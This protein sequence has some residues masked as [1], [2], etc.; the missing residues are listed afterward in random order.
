MDRVE[1]AGELALKAGHYSP[2]YKQLEPILRT[3]QD[4]ITIGTSE[5]L[6]HID[7][8][9]MSEDQTFIKLFKS[10]LILKLRGRCIK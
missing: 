10:S 8:L 9:D 5:K 6:H 4:R 1:R 7:L 3:N 2:R